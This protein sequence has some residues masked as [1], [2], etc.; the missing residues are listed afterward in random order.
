MYGELYLIFNETDDGL[1]LLTASFYPNST[2]L[3][4]LEEVAVD[5]HRVYVF[6]NYQ[7]LLDVI[8]KGFSSFIKDIDDDGEETCR[9]FTLKFEINFNTKNLIGYVK[10]VMNNINEHPDNFLDMICYADDS[11]REDI[12][13]LYLHTARK[14]IRDIEWINE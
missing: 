14:L 3:S 10:T 13:A 1:A 2:L 5:F 9:S 12:T 4:D 11:C 6:L 7:Y 8:Q